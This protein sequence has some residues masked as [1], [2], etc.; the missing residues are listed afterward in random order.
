[1]RVPG[2]RQLAECLG[3]TGG[4]KERK[5]LRGNGI[6]PS[7]MSGSLAEGEIKLRDHFFLE[8]YQI[9]WQAIF[10]ENF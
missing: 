1:M 3:D 7:R 2:G 4:V 5:F 6:G 10:D 8:D 9:T